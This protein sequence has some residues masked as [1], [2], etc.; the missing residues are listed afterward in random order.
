MSEYILVH[1][2]VKG[3]KWGVIR[4]LSA[5]RKNRRTSVDDTV[6]KPK[7][8]SSKPPTRS[9]KDITDT[10]LKQILNRMEMEKKYNQFTAK[11]KSAAQKFVSEVLTGAAKQTAT[12]YAAQYM[13]SGVEYLIKSSKAKAK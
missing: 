11:E 5:L 12:K 8:K 9:V 13:S 7:K 3:M 1:H 6:S 2:G 4:S 10:E